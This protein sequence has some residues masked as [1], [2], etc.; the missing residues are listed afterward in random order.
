MAASKTEDAASQY[1]AARLAEIGNRNDDAL[2]AYIK[3]Y[4][5]APDSAVLADRIFDSAIR[6]GD[7]DAALRAV[8][9]QELRG[10]VSSEA[11]LL[12][13]ADAFSRKNWGMAKLAADE[14]PARGNFGFMAPMLRSWVNVAQG[15]ADGLAAADAQTDPLLAFY[16]ND[17]RIYIQLANREFANAKLGLRGLV[18]VGGEYVRDLMLR[19]APAIAAQ[20]DEM[21]ADALIGTA[22]GGDRLAVAALPIDK[23]RRTKLSPEDGLSALHVRI[24]AALLEQNVNDQALVLA[25][26]ASWYAPDSD[27]AKLMLVS[28]LDANGL[29]LQASA[30]AGTITR[31]SYYWPQAVKR[32][33]ET[34]TPNE[35]AG[36]AR[37]AAQDWPKS[38][39]LALFA[40]QSQEAAGDLAGAVASYRIIVD[41]AATS[42]ISPRQR[43]YYQLLLASALDNVGNW[44][45]ARAELDAALILDPNNAQILNYLGYTLLERNEEIALARAMVARAFEIAPNST[46][47]M[48]SMGWA[49]FRTGE[50]S[51]A[52]ML[53]ENA[54]KAS[55]NDPA[56][57]EHLGDAYWRSGRL[58]DARYAWAVASQ[59]AEGV[60][61]TRL[62]GKI[63]L[64]LSAP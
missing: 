42:G 3:L 49:H 43:A 19:A 35:A 29:R 10:E 2:K 56:I 48:D 13:F 61:A 21:F 7:M 5:D 25:R 1:A 39:S 20:G 31:T 53:L 12:L 51:E 16:S 4:R 50:F 55:G 36:L 45:A 32:L 41:N 9:V 22:M 60:A 54:A 57:N 62:A 46:A 26:I 38:A 6:A 24:A 15:N 63:D 28:A 18:S 64:G 27:A 30:L 58:R 40:A 34:L 23:T 8:R 14:L 33:A 47:I 17:Q 11:P 37:E 59:T 44:R 52:V